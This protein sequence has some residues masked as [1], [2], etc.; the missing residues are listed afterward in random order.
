MLTTEH[1]TLAR[2]FLN[3]AD[4]EYDAGDIFQASEKLWGAATHVVIAEMQRR[5]IRDNKHANITRF[6][7]TFSEEFGE[8][9]VYAWFKSAEA[10][11]SNFYHGWMEDHQFEENRELVH[12]FVNR[13]LELTGQA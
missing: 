2:Q 13:M 12:L 3:D 7:R 9:I 4:A 11:H 8:P 6:V 5:D 10:I 1:V